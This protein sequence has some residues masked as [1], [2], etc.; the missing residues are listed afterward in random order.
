MIP[1][2]RIRLTNSDVDSNLNVVFRPLDHH[3]TLIARKL[4][5][6]KEGGQRLTDHTLIINGIQIDLHRMEIGRGMG[7]KER[8]AFLFD[9]KVFADW[10][11]DRISFKQAMQSNRFYLYSNHNRL[12][13]VMWIAGEVL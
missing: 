5:T 8:T 3:I 6:A 9:E 4:A 1:M 11:E 12:L 2:R 10:A 13:A 7:F